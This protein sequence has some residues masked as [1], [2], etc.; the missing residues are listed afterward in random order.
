LVLVSAGVALLA[1]VGLASLVALRLRR[2]AS[3]PCAF[4]KLPAQPSTPAADMTPVS[5]AANEPGSPLAIGLGSI[6]ADLMSHHDPSIPETVAI[7]NGDPVRSSDYEGRLD[8]YEACIRASCPGA[9]VDQSLGPNNIALTVAVTNVLVERYGAEHGIAVSQTDITNGLTQQVSALQ[10]A[11][12]LGGPAADFVR[13]D[14]ALHGLTD[15]QQIV[16]DP[17]WRQQMCHS[18]LR[19]KTIDALG[20]SELPANQR[21]PLSHAA[22][23]QKLEQRLLSSA[24]VQ[25]K[26]P[27]HLLSETAM[28]QLDAPP[29]PPPGPRSR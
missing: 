26:V 9:A 5:G 7:A 12:K 28:Q 4:A 10:G 21:S 20:L 11:Q 13:Q 27:A 24:H 3:E 6:L 23:E 16:A 1:V 8:M 14:L 18:L 19:G 2:Q 17:G 15:P 25:I 29:P 22:G